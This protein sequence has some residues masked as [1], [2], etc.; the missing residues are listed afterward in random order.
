MHSD[1]PRLKLHGKALR[2]APDS[3]NIRQAITRYLEQL[4][5]HSTEWSDWLDTYTEG[6]LITKFGVHI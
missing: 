6:E 1:D 2:F 5:P 3:S 4:D